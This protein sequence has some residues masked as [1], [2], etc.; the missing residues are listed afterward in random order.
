MTC[1]LL[2][3]SIQQ[4]ADV[5]DVM[6]C[7]RYVR[8]M[9][10]KRRGMRLGEEIVNTTK[11][12]KLGWRGAPFLPGARCLPGLIGGPSIPPPIPML[13]DKEIGSFH[14]NGFIA[15]TAISTAREVA[16]LRVLFD[17]LLRT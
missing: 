14:E 10:V 2:L 11:F 4:S 15:L 6:R 3:Q 17:R 5:A 13:N 12:R 7:L 8:P 9:S 1:A 16:S